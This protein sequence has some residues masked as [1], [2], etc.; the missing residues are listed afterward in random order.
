MLSGFNTKSLVEGRSQH[1]RN[2]AGFS[3]T[4]VHKGTH[5]HVLTAGTQSRRMFVNE[6]NV[7]ETPILELEVTAHSLRRTYAIA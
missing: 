1:Q 3:G 7:I 4:Y 6:C 5:A 2:E